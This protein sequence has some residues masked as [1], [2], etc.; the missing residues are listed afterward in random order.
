MNGEKYRD[1]GKGWISGRNVASCILLLCSGWLASATYA[2]GVW[3]TTHTHAHDPGNATF[4][5]LAP[6]ATQLN[7]VVSL[8]MRNTPEM[9]Q[10]ISSLTM[11]P[12]FGRSLS[13]AD[14]LNL[15]DPTEAQ[16]QQVASYLI[17]S[18]FTDVEIAPNRLLVTA[19]G[20]AAVA[21]VAFNTE[22]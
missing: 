2:Q 8:Q 6:D 21:R 14:L 19:A 9:M 11:S 10:A 4:I 20:T 1:I 13:S 22:L 18:G 15:Y 7:V 12:A 3:A 16:A 17:E 5:A